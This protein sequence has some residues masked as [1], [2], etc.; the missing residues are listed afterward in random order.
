MSQTKSKQAMKK[1]YRQGDVFIELVAAI[2]ADAVKQAP[3]KK[4]ILALGEAT[5]HHHALETEDPAD[6]WKRG[7]EQFVSVAAGASL[8]HQEHAAIELPAGAYR[9]TRQREYSPT[10]IRNVLD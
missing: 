9:V 6:W 4:I 1:Q 5:G 8:T 2:P 7:E 3:S 10:E